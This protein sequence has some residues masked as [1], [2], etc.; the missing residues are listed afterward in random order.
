[1]RSSEDEKV[2]KGVGKDKRL[3]SEDE[4]VHDRVHLI[5]L[6]SQLLNF[7][8]HDRVPLIFSTSQLLNF[9]QVS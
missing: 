5:F 3:K 9:F 4:K 8:P 6:T 2:R 1:V 7:F